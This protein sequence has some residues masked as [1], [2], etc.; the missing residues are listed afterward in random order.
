MNELLLIITLLL[1]YSL[2]IVWYLLFGEKGLTAFYA[3]II[4]LANIEVNILVRAFGIEQTL[5]NVL[6]A[7]TFLITD[8][9]SELYGKKSANKAV[10]IGIFAAVTMVIISQIWIFY[11]PAHGDYAMDSIITLFKGTPRIILSSLAVNLV[12]QK[13]DVWLYHS[14]WKFT[15]KK[16]TSKDKFL[17]LRNNG[18][19]LISQLLNAI[20]FNICAFAGIFDF[21]TMINIIVSS[22]VIFLITALLDTPII[23]LVRYI[24]K[25]K[26]NKTIEIKTH[27]HSVEKEESITPC[28]EE[29]KN[30]NESDTERENK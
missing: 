7:G 9:L 6:F 12:C 20:L 27:N 30:A 11:V 14:I 1:T 16:S 19:T 4:I 18:S 3:V 22:Y 25:R 21:D 17:W 13:F 23:Y 2:V 15:A 8:I 26:K 29:N 10:N 5:G 24:N 28:I